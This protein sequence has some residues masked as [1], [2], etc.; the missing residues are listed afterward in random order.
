MPSLNQFHRQ[1]NHERTIA[2]SGCAYYNFFTVA[3]IQSCLHLGGFLSTVTNV[4]SAI[5]TDAGQRYM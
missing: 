5:C 1:Y 3:Q 4:K 2:D